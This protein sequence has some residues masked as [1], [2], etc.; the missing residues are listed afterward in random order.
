MKNFM[1]VIFIALLLLGCS[2]SSENKEGGQIAL[3]AAGT[4]SGSGTATLFGSIEN[5]PTVVLV[6]SA[7]ASRFTIEERSIKCVNIES[8]IEEPINLEIR[9]SALFYR[10]A[11]VGT[12]SNTEISLNYSES[13][14]RVALRLRANEDSTYTYSESWSAAD[15]Q[16]NM[17]FQGKLTK[18]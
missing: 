7:S 17:Q 4:Y 15:P 5:C 14:Y 6:F 1:L 2:G 3:D 10:N 13:G 8:E 11:Q 9:G 18:R 16:N 12:L